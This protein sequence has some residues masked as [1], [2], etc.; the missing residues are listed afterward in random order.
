M[1]D[2]IRK[3]VELASP[4]DSGDKFECY[5]IGNDYPLCLKWADWD[6][7]LG[8]PAGQI[9]L[10]AIAAQLVRQV[11]ALPVGNFP[12]DAPTSLYSLRGTVDIWHKRKLIVSLEGPDRTLNT[13]RAIVES[14]V[15]E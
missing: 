4:L 14:G 11:D 15:L 7:A 9:L 10:D 3:A 12:D 1:S 2:L 8:S 6:A 5:N 13:I